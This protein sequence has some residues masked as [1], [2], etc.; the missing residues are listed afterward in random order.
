MKHTHT[1]PKSYL[2]RL[3]QGDD[4]IASLEEFAREEGVKSA[5]FTGLGSLQR[6]RIGHYDFQKTHQYHFNDYNE[7]LEVL[8]AV[9]NITQLEG[10]PLIH[11]H[12]SLS[13]RDCSQLGGHADKGCIVNLLEIQL[14]VLEG[15]FHRRRDPKLGLNIIDLP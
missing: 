4:L 13:R 7:D 11:V 6:A 9:G 3:D 12:L 5:S 8:S 15:I 10:N 14:Q 1:A 2:I